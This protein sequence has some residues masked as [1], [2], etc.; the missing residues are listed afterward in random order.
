MHDDD[1]DD[2]DDNSFIKNLVLEFSMTCL[3]Q[4]NHIRLRRA[5]DPNKNPG[6]E[7]DI[8]AKAN[9]KNGDDASIGVTTLKADD[10]EEDGMDD[11][12]SDEGLANDEMTINPR[13]AATTEA[14]KSMAVASR[15]WR[16]MA[17]WA[18][19]KKELAAQG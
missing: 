10:F 16:F 5:N 15:A 4:T 18:D 7:D 3:P 11:D 2:N 9:S 8:L 6:Q 13:V 14:D 12:Q 1:N 17:G 19:R